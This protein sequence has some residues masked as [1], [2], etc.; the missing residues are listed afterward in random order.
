MLSE[1]YQKLMCVY[2]FVVWLL[3]VYGQGRT[4]GEGGLKAPWIFENQK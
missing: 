1:T 3:L 2:I 4:H